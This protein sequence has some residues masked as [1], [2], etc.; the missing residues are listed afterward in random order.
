MS[1]KCFILSSFS[2]ISNV[3]VWKLARDVYLNNFWRK[4][5]GQLW[6]QILA[7]MSGKSHPKNKTLQIK[8]FTPG[9][10]LGTDD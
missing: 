1:V 3:N 8:T 6:C 2:Q 7:Y 9:L 5:I 10:F 4:A